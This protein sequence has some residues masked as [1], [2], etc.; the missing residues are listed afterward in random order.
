LQ[1]RWESRTNAQPGSARELARDVEDNIVLG[2]RALR[3]MTELAPEAGISNTDCEARER[4][5][6][7]K[8]LLPLR[9]YR[10]RLEPH[11]ARQKAKQNEAELDGDLPSDDELKFPGAEKP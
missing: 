2:E 5:I 6:E 9:N 1:Y 3:A 7:R 10:K 4:V 8:L 11:V